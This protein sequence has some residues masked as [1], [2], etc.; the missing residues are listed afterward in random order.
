MNKRELADFYGVSTKTLYNYKNALEKVE[1]DGIIKYGGKHNIYR[2]M[3]L[4]Y[5]LNAL[6][7]E[8][9]HLTELEKMRQDIDFI[10]NAL[11]II[12]ENKSSLEP[13]HREGMLNTV[14]QAIKNLEKTLN[15]L[16]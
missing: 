7:K 12:L 5:Y 11:P 13:E 16:N 10:K 15:D 2:A 4:Y 14:K 8:D 3:V 6:P 1:A 9:E